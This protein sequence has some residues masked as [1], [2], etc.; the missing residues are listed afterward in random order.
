MFFSH[1]VAVFNL[2]CVCNVKISLHFLMVFSFEHTLQQDKG[3]P[4]TY[5]KKAQ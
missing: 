4:D 2:F 5:L 1:Y 3:N